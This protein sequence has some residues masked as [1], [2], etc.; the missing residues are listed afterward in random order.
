VLDR[1][2]REVEEMS[3]RENTADPA[4]LERGLAEIQQQLEQEIRRLQ[5]AIRRIP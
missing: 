3:R 2:A 5:E 1:V 4:A